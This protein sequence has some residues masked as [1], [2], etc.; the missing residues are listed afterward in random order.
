MDPDAYLCQLADVFNGISVH[1]PTISAIIAIVLAG[2]LL[3]VSGF[4]SASEIAFFSLSPSDLSAIDEKK[5]PS[6]EKIS[7]LLEDTERLLATILITNNFVNVTIIM[8]CNFFFM[9]VFEFH[10]PIAEFL[11]LT[12][13]LTFLLLLFGEIM[14]KIYSAQKTLAF[15][16]FSAPGIWMFRSLFYPVASM[17]VRSTSFLNKHFARKNHNISVDELSHALELT[18][19]EE[20]KEENNI[21]EGIIRFGGETAKEVMTSRLDVVDLDIR[22]PFKDVLQCI[23]ENAYSRIPIYSENRDNI[24]GILYIKDLLPHLNKVD[25]RWQSLIRPAYFV[26]ETKMI[27]DLLRDFQANKIHIAIVVDE[28]GGTSGIV[29]MEDIIEEIVGEIHD[30]YDDEERTYAVLNDHTWVFEAK[31]QLT[32]FYKITKVD[33]EVFDEVAGDSDTLAGL[34]LELKGEFPALHEKV[35]Y[36]HYEFEVLEMD[37]RRILKVKFTINTPPSDSDKKD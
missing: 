10:S 27:D 15:C 6:D 26:P 13:I 18:D 32:D 2:L 31:T 35:T 19:K 21:L 7:K 29:T 8:L 4:A 3:L 33:E 24:K 22:T 34:L 20:L 23:I 17:L 11:I 1:S 25:F 12:V 37:N 30:E 28:F 36:D 5:H 16:R 14:P 9:S